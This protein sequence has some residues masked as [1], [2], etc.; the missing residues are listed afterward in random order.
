MRRSRNLVRRLP[1]TT[2][3]TRPER[4]RPTIGER[5]GKNAEVFRCSELGTSAASSGLA[6][7]SGGNHPRFSSLIASGHRPG[8]DSTIGG[9]SIPFT[10]SRREL[11]PGYPSWTWAAMSLQLTRSERRASPPDSSQAT[12]KDY[13][14]ISGEASSS[15]GDATAAARRS[16]ANHPHIFHNASVSGSC[17]SKRTRMGFS[18]SWPMYFTGP[19]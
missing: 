4:L 14:V 3:A 9:V 13:R 19:R 8:S 7:W 2:W 6:S 16:A 1:L 5:Q 11:L 15:V 10:A 12:A 18:P 17:S